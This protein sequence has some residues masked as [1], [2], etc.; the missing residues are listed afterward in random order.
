M[1]ITTTFFVLAC[2]HHAQLLKLV[3]FL[4]IF[5]ETYSNQ[6]NYLLEEWQFY[7]QVKKNEAT[8]KYWIWFITCVTTTYTCSSFRAVY[9]FEIE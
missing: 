9:N 3:K 2:N 1:C 5:Q 8:E 6:D 7:G 4:Q